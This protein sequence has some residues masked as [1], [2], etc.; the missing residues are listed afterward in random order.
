MY[1]KI[2]FFN[3]LIDWEIYQL[4]KLL[5]QFT[6]LVWYYQTSMVN[7][8]KHKPQRLMF[9]NRNKIKM[10]KKII[11]FLKIIKTNNYVC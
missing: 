8:N 10:S 9:N 3:T 6:M 2:T 7:C 11:Y 5:D 1:T 4:G